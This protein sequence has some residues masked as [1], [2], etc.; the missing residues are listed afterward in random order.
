MNFTLSPGYSGR[1]FFAY[2][3]IWI[4]YN[5]DGDFDDAGEKVYSS[6]KRKNSLTA[7]FVTSSVIGTARM[8]ISVSDRSDASPCDVNLNGEVEDYTIQIVTEGPKAPVAD[9]TAN[10]TNIGKIGWYSDGNRW[11]NE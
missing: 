2:W 9:F 4:D 10:Q 11:R 7:S 6:S 5:A 8:R 1:S 3:N